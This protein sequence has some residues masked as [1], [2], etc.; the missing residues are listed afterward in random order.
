MK[1]KILGE[2]SYNESSESDQKVGR[3]LLTIS[4]SRREV[5]RK[6]DLVVAANIACKAILATA[7]DE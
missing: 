7:N 5:G 1:H 6:P 3:T 2:G 4:V